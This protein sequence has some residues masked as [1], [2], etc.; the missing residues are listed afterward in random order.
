LLQWFHDVEV[1]LEELFVQKDLSK[2]DLLRQALRLYQ[3]V[4]AAFLA[5]KS[6]FLKTMRSKR[7]S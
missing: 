5:G 7:Q 1:V 4:D 3:L 6:S 2:T